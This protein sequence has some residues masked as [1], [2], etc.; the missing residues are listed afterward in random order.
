MTVFQEEK[1]RRKFISQPTSVIWSGSTG[2]VM[3]NDLKRQLGFSLPV[4]F[5]GHCQDTTVAGKELLF[6]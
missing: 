1:R 4:V 2:N 3:L 6:N 5:A